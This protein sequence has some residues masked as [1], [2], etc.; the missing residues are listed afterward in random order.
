MES[1]Q[2]YPIFYCLSYLI[3]MWT[4]LLRVFVSVA[5]FNVV[6]CDFLCVCNYN[7]DKPV[8]PTVSIVH[9]TNVLFISIKYI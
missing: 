2:R 6:C 9:V 7:I 3:R 4:A 1:R 5:L 8:Y